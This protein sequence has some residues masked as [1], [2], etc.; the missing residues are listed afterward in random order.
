MIL[1]PSP[2]TP[3]TADLLARAVEAS[4]WPAGAFS[5]VHADPPVARALWTDARIRCV[6]FTGS[7]TV[8]WKIKEEAS[9]RR[10]ILELGGNAAAIVCADAD[11]RRAAAKLA[12]AAFAYAGQVCIKAQRILVAR[13]VERDFLDAFLEESRKMTP[14]DPSDAG[15]DSRPDDRRGERSARR[16]VGR[17]GARPGRARAPRAAP[18][19]IPAFSGNRL[20]SAPGN[21][22][23]GPGDLRAGRDRRR[24]RG[25]RR[26]LRGGERFPLRPPGVDL[27]DRAS[28]TPWPRSRSSR[29]A[30]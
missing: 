25:P 10:V 22:G 27:H 15:D 20:G 5:L 13:E 3:M 1:K 9:R 23:P 26:G 7:D 4:G 19:R 29:S 11:V 2:R 8:G 30:G 6:S 18:R 12:V 14:R 17:R 24:L 28:G 21:E 16:G